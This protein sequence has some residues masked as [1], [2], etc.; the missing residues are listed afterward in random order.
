MKEKYVPNLAEFY[1]KPTFD[2]SIDE[3]SEMYSKT[4]SPDLD[5][6]IFGDCIAGMRSMNEESVDCIIADPPFGLDFDGKTHM[7]NRKKGLVIDGYKEIHPNDYSGF[8][9]EWIGLIPRVL[10][11]TGS[12]FIFSG[13]TN[14]SDILN[15]VKKSGLHV[16]NHVIWVY[17]FAV[18]C[19]KKFS[20]SHYHVIY[21]VKNE[22]KAF[23]NQVQNYN[24][25]V[26]NISR[27]YARGEMKN[28]T[29]LPIELVTRCIDYA[30]KVGDIVLDPFMGN[31]TTACGARSQFRHFMGYEINTNLQKIISTNL[32]LYPPGSLYKPYAERLPT[33]DELAKKY[34]AAYRKYLEREGLDHS[35]R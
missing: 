14:L 7:Y 5:R 4:S 19:S 1:F 31:G 25:D 8:S 32:D 23:F 17:Q 30:T 13:W 22:K 11:E 33:I 10:K 20:T 18:Y 26:W 9:G 3:A 29:K 12:A 16:R 6:V 21:A 28:G 15:A 35:V 34:P 24:T 2:W 27:T